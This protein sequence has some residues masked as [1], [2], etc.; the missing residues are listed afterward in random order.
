MI[1]VKCWGE[2]DDKIQAAFFFFSFNNGPEVLK[3]D[4]V[5][6]FVLFVSALQSQSQSKPVVSHDVN[7]FPAKEYILLGQFAFNDSLAQSLG[8]PETCI[9]RTLLQ[10]GVRKK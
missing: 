2:D 5:F 3:L 4:K 1:V 7:P 10:T 8:Y 6:C 9:I